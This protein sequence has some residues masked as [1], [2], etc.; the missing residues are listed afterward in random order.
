MKR[1]VARSAG[2]IAL[3]SVTS[4]LLGLARDQI[5]AGL[6]GRS[7]GTDA[8]FVA[9]NVSQVFYDLIIQGAVS[10]A[11]VPVFSTYAG[12]KQRAHLWRLASLVLNLAI[13]VLTVIVLALVIAAPLVVRLAGPGFGPDLQRQATDLT[14]LT[15][16]AVVFLGASSVLT[17]LLYSLEDFVFPAFC[18][19]LFN[20]CMIVS[21]V[22]F[23]RQLGVGS[24]ALGMLLGA[25]AQVLFQLPPLVRQRVSFS[26]GVNL[27]DPDLRR[28]LLLYA[29]VAAGFI[30][31]GV[32]VFI[33]RNLASRTAEGSISAMQFATRLIQFPLGL[34][35]TAIAGASLPVLAQRAGDAEQFQATLGAGLRMISLLILP[36]ATGLAVL[37]RPIV[38]VLFQHGAFG[39]DDTQMTALALLLYLPGLPAAALDQMLIFA[40]YARKD[41]LTPVLIGVAAIGVYLLVAL[42]LIGRMG[43]PGLVLANSA[44]WVA[45]AGIS[46]VVLRRKMGGL[47]GMN[48]RSTLA[49]TAAA[50][51][52][53][54]GVSWLLLAVL[55]VIVPAMGLASDLARLALAGGG[56]AL[57][58]VGAAWLLRLAE[59]RT[60]VASFHRKS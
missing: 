5:T 16:L 43:M 19:A 4:R 6:C 35:P 58:F 20:G 1:T 9:T 25:I 17:A 26:I 55:A 54:A 41:T 22:L 21:A 40:F 30:V 57:A 15:L 14:R 3:G 44:Q 39:A 47:G 2:I 13:I 28:I 29:P 36:A 53:M 11:L 12:E 24:L 42:S 37:A 59:L 27:H 10:S 7:G 51:L 60:L 31:S 46:Y 33:D 8:F 34:I 18:S 52:V 49:R 38:A 23:H 32:Q 45:H 50:C 56:G 48:L